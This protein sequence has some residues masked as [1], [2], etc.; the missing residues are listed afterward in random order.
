MNW[1]ILKSVQAAAM[2]YRVQRSPPT[3]Q[4]MG[5]TATDQIRL[6]A[7]VVVCVAF[8]G[9]F[10]GHATA[11][12]I[13][14]VY[15]LRQ[16]NAGANQIYGFRFDETTGVLS[17]LPGF[18]VSSGGTGSTTLYT[19]QLAYRNGRLYVVNDGSNTLSVFN[20]NPTTGALTSPY[21]PVSL[22]LAAWACVAVHP[23]GSPVVVGQTGGFLASLN[24]SA[25]SAIPAAGSPFSTGTALPWSCQFSQS[26]GH[27]YTGGNSATTFAG[28]SVNT[29]T[30]VLTP[31][32]GSPFESGGNNPLGY[33]TDNSGRL[34]SASFTGGHVRAFTTSAGVPTGV[35]GNPF[36]SGLV[37]TM[38]GVVHPGGFYMVA[39]R[40]G[41][42]VGV[43]QIAGTGAATTL[44]A[45]S[46]SPFATTGPNALAV[47][48]SGGHLLAASLAGRNLTVFQVNQGTGTLSTVSVQPANTLG[49]TGN[50]TGLAFAPT[51]AGFVYSLTQVNGGANQIYGFRINPST[52]ALTL[53]PGFPVASGG[54]GTTAAAAEQMTYV[55]GRLYVLN[56][57]SDTVSA[58]KVNRTTGALTPLVFSP[59]AVAAGI[60]QGCV[61]I[62]P[63][64]SPLVVGYAGGTGGMASFVVGAT[65]ATLAP[66][67]PFP[68]GGPV[69]F[70]C[71]FSQDGNY[72]Y[73]GGNIGTTIAGLSVSTAT[74]VLTPLAGSPFAG[75][76]L[77]GFAGYATDIGGRLFSAML[78]SA[79]ELRAF[80]TASGIPTAVSGN[81]FAATGLNQ[82]VHG[83]L[84]PG[85]FYMT[86]ARNSSNVGV[87]QIAGAGAATTLSAVAGAPFASGGTQTSALALTT[88][89]AYLVAANGT[90]RNLTVF[91]V[92]PA[93]G[94]L[95]NVALQAVNTLGASGRVTGVAFAAAVAPFF[96]DPLTALPPLSRV[97]KTIHIE[98]LRARINSVRAQYGFEP[99]L[100]TDPLLTAATTVV[101]AAHISD[102]R[103]ALA[104]VYTAAGIP[105]PSYTD[106][107]LPAGTIL[108]KAVHITE[109]RAA[110]IAIE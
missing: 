65:T 11:G 45:V 15:A 63:S 34:F 64:G 91:N 8:V 52:G 12:Q 36:V 100:Y 96:D 99:Y 69:S 21:G 80:T 103:A 2:K 14:F 1:T 84:H 68:T 76:G 41:N 82:P 89:G 56:D 28:F 97:I 42:G 24:V 98:E 26:G 55:N 92:N 88:N 6:F 16:V 101:K 77:G 107:A 75:G 9:L 44:T 33:A 38:H 27:V 19:E 31:L 83:I 57:G 48:S 5:W 17:P 93:T 105:P 54:N 94:G 22:G 86:A 3:G 20:V 46:G 10:A 104:Q 66:G 79:S 50:I 30:G 7:R 18:P 102:L 32:A 58:F 43:F 51:E 23:S 37:G 108:V 81:P 73:T 62:H 47:S 87:F 71:A 67:G 25:V 59:I 85:G 72:V 78:L 106:P 95:T 40:T 39:D 109:L 29:G 35:T 110:V 60:S 13:G 90:S 74:G 53:L 4:A 70:S 49:A 61:A